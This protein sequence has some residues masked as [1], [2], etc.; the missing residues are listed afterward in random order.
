MIHPLLSPTHPRL[1]PARS[2][3]RLMTFAFCFV[4]HL[5]E[6]EPSMLLL[7]WNGPLEPGNVTRGDTMQ[8]SDVPFPEIELVGSSSLV[9]GK[10]Y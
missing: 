2:F 7:D 4:T 6:P 8:G 9:T 5:L 3:A 10:A 1:L